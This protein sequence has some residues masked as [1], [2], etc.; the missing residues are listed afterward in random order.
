ML[1]NSFKYLV[2]LPVLLLFYF[3]LP[4]K[5]R[6][7]WLLVCSYFFYMSWNAAHGILLFA[8]TAVSYTGARLLQRDG[9]GA[10][11]RKLAFALT[12]CALFAP[13]V[14]YKYS[15]FLLQ[16]AFRALRIFAGLAGAVG[17]PVVAASAQVPEL[18]LALPVGISFFTF[19]AAGYIVDVYRGTVNAEKNFFRYAL[20][21]SFFPQLVAG[22]I[23]RSGTLLHQ[24]DAPK[25]F[26]FDRAKDAV[27]LMLWGYFLK[28]V[29]ADRATIFVDSAYAQP[30]ETEGM[31]MLFATVFFAFQIYG[32][33]YGYSLIAKGS[34]K[35]LGFDLM[36]NFKSP[37]CALNVQ[38]FWRRWHISLSTWFRDYVY[39]PLGGSRCSAVRTSLN[40]ML[41]MALSGLWHG[42]GW[43]FVAWGLLH[44][45][46]QLADRATAGIQKKLP[47][48]LRRLATFFWVC[49]GWCFFRS[50]SLKVALHT[51]KSIGS[52][53]AEHKQV[54]DFFYM[55]LDWTELKL[56]YVCIALLL[57][58][59]AL[60]NRGVCV[61]RE[62]QKCSAV[63]QIL[64]VAA[65]VVFIVAVGVW[66]GTYNAADFIYFQF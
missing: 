62:I 8:C 66:G 48:L 12:L 26:D 20:F 58:V 50:P 60:N 51:L 24:F 34:A 19:Q 40:I 33:F 47:V 64:A 2:F 18:D 14:F 54:H 17:K 11:G 4:L 31:T 55:K 45:F 36:D 7:W 5:L 15:N 41:V 37:Y 49:V 63:A 27:F 6:N 52:F 42:A 56:L 44:G 65:G 59:D 9:G 10:K 3:V 32:D 28:M 53:I 13:L 22:P 39:F 35:L 25:R 30:Y 29:L 43:H 57:A 1:F 38:D 23:E 16:N 61:R 21:V 46:L